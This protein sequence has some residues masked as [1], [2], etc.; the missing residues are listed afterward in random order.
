METLDYDPKDFQIAHDLGTYLDS[1]DYFYVRFG[2][3][4]IFVKLTM[5]GQDYCEEI[6]AIFCA[7]NTS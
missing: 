6:K 2:Y 4:F 7:R 1:T 5:K 3:N